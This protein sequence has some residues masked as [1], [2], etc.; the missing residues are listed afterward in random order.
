MIARVLS[1]SKGRKSNLEL[2]RIVAMCLIIAHHYVANSGVKALYSMAAHPSRTIF[3]QFW[4]MLGKPAINMFVLI[5][6]WFMCTSKLTPTRYL[7]VVGPIL[8]YRISWHLV[9][10]ALGLSSFSW[11]TMAK[12]PLSLLRDAGH[13][14]SFSS[15]FTVFYL[16]IPALNAVIQK[17]DRCSFGLALL[18]LLALQT[19]LGTFLGNK[20]LF[21]EVSW[22]CIT[23]LLAAFLRL[24]GGAWTSD[25]RLCV[26]GLACS[27]VLCWAFIIAIDLFLFKTK[28]FYYLVS[29]PS[30]LGSLAVGLFAFLTFK[31]LEI[32]QSRI[33]NRIAAASF[34]V[35]LVHANSLA[36]RLLWKPGGLF[37]V[38]WAFGHLPLPLL[39]LHAAG[40]VVTVYAIGFVIDAIEKSIVAR[41]LYR[42]LDKR[43]EAGFPRLVALR[44]KASHVLSKL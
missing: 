27:L 21:N 10:S 39:M 25:L 32:P 18:S 35:L 41:P 9:G 30:R 12:I 23:Y 8:F 42:R 26:R 33:I 28:A 14:G 6:G 17:L 1:T 29:N 34:G 22:F 11:T 7:K 44:E 37:D 2:L 36:R 40:A 43:A 19:G 24:H 4:G 5:T 31:N 13:N 15:S 16:L 20:Y 38:K 3:I